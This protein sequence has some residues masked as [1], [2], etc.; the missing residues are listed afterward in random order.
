MGHDLYRAAGKLE[1]GFAHFWVVRRIVKQAE[2][3]CSIQ[4]L[5]SPWKGKWSLGFGILFEAQQ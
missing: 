4:R 1:G 2:K 5:Q 3:G